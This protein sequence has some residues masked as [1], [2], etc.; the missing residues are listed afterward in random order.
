MQNSKGV[1]KDS[2]NTPIT[3]VA[4]LLESGRRK[5]QTVEKDFSEMGNLFPCM[6]LENY[7]LFFW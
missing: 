5:N 3:Q 7:S 1:F 6:I 4:L 2:F